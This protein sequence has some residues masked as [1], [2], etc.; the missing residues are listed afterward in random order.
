MRAA[1]GL[2]PLALGLAIFTAWALGPRRRPRP[3]P[4][5]WQQRG[6]TDIESAKTDATGG[7]TSPGTVAFGLYG[8]GLDGP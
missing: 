1:A 2:A 7:N 3:G 5:N 6:A 4:S 8:A